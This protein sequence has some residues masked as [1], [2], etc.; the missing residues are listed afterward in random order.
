MGPR[1]SGRDSGAPAVDCS[2]AKTLR[3]QTVK[4]GAHLL[5]AR[6]PFRFGKVVFAANRH[7]H[8]AVTGGLVR[9]GVSPLF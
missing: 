9:A 8:H 4:L 3:L 5:E 7:R 1:T 2:A 6:S